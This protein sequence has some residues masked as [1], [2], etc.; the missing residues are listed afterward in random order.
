MKRGF[1]PT[2]AIALLII[3]NVFL[4]KFVYDNIIKDDNRSSKQ[5]QVKNTQSSMVKQTP[6]PDKTPVPK[7]A[8]VTSDSSLTVASTPNDGVDPASGTQP[9][10]QEKEEQQVVSLE[11]QHTDSL[12]DEIVGDVDYGEE[13]SFPDDGYHNFIPAEEG[14]LDTIR[15]GN[16]NQNKTMLVACIVS[17]EKRSKMAGVVGGGGTVEKFG[18]PII[19]FMPL[20]DSPFLDIT[21]GPTDLVKLLPQDQAEF[22]IKA[23]TS[24]NA[25]PGEY[26]VTVNLVD[27][28]NATSASKKYID[29]KEIQYLIRI[30]PA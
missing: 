3:V 30:N 4:G 2:I 17:I 7:G 6:L 9:Q 28:N 5:A 10:T 26:R 25:A 23:R 8:D 14:L 29:L 20:K 1:F 16:G 24:S 21:I 15:I 27:M 12:P 18:E 13:D 11:V 22:K 19:Y